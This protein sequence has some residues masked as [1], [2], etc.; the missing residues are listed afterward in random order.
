MLSCVK[1]CASLVA[2]FLAL[3]SLPATG[4]RPDRRGDIFVSIVTVDFMLT[5]YR[6]QGG[7]AQEHTRPVLAQLAAQPFTGTSC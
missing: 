6:E 3:R 1:N 2:Q 5:V 4:G 7:A